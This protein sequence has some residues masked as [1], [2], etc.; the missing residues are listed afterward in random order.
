VDP[1]VDERRVA[2]EII[3]TLVN[4]KSAMWELVLKPAGVPATVY[5]PLQRRRDPVTG[6]E[7]SKRKLAPL[8]LEA[9]DAL[10]EGSR[11]VRRLIEIGA[12]W[13]KFHL[14]Q[15]EYEARATVQKAREIL[16]QLETMAAREAKQRELAREQELRR[17]EQ[18]QR[19]VRAR[20][21]PLLLAEFEQFASNDSHQHRGYLLQDLLPRLFDCFGLPVARSFTRNDG[22]EQIDGAFRFDGWTYIVECRW[23]ERVADIRDLDGLKGQISRSGRQTMGVFLSVMGWSPNVVGLLKQNPDKAILLFDGFDL[24]TVLSGDVDLL[25]LLRKKVDG[26]NLRGEPFVSAAN[27]RHQ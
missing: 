4:L 17:L 24:R 7:L 18:E 21:L 16:G 20:Q 27:L 25:T 1:D 23:R 5:Q 3:A 15:N 12:G 6:R 2:I 9:V 19:Q 8:V 14:A 11:I 22:G 10:P 13:N 26:L